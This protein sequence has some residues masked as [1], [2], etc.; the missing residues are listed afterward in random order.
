MSLELLSG[1]LVALVG[2]TA[3]VMLLWGVA[4][5]YHNYR[6]R[7]LLREILLAVKR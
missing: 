1:R 3:G 2:G 7:V 6:V 5:A 4:Q